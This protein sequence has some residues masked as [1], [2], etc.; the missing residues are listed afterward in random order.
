MGWGRAYWGH[1]SWKSNDDWHGR[2]SW[3]KYWKKKKKCDDEDDGDGNDDIA[4][5]RWSQDHEDHGHRYK[6]WKK[7][8]REQCTLHSE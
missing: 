3:K 7:C 8:H 1:K 5:D 2:W 6:H 4:A